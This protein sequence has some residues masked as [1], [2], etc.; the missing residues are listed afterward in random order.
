MAAHSRVMRAGEIEQVGSPMEI[1]SN[2]ATDFVA[3]FFGSHR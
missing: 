1:Y 2:P 3:D